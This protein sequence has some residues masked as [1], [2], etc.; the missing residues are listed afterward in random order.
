MEPI[1]IST[2][3]IKIPLLIDD[4]RTVVLEIDPDDLLFY[5]RFYHYYQEVQEKS[6]YFTERMKSIQAGLPDEDDISNEDFEQQRK[7]IEET[8]D[9]MKEKIN[10]LFGEG[11]YES[12][13]GTKKNIFAVSEFMTAILPAI[14]TK[15]KEKIDKFM[16]LKK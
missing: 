6:V 4:E 15:R 3:K 8:C 1:K 11:T 16:K 14:T 5:E 9:F 12:I 7:L 13:F 10:G 2:G